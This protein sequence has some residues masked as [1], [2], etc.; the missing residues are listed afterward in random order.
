MTRVRLRLA[1]LMYPPINIA[2]GLN[3][4]GLTLILV[5]HFMFLDVSAEKPCSPTYIGRDC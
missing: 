5:M 1:Y 2:C 3:E 4:T